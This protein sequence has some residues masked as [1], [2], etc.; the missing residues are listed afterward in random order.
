MHDWN[1]RSP[2][3][4][5][6]SFSESPCSVLKTTQSCSTQVAQAHTLT[7]QTM[8]TVWAV[9][10]MTQWNHLWNVTDF[11][12][13][14]S[15]LHHTVSDFRSRAAAAADCEDI[16]WKNCRMWTTTA[17]NCY[18]TFRN[19]NH[20]LDIYTHFQSFINDE[21]CSCSLLLL[22]WE[23][24]VMLSSRVAH[25]VFKMIMCCSITASDLVG[26]TIA[27]ADIERDYDEQ[28]VENLSRRKHHWIW[29]KNNHLMT[30]KQN[31]FF[32][33]EIEKQFSHRQLNSLQ[34]W[35]YTKLQN[36][37]IS[38]LFINKQRQEWN[39]KHSHSIL[40]YNVMWVWKIVLIRCAAMSTDALLFL[41][42]Y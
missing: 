14:H 11:P 35:W 17:K 29:E 38:N 8:T 34:Q 40:I 18:P 15:A 27:A 3:L 37:H 13:H 26:E 42:I 41:Q 22:I 19:T 21:M 2:I 12:H 16:A 32:W 7:I 33:T 39:C 1:V 23:E 6:V 24:A 31:S 30:L 5:T 36:T 9:K 10:R 25:I 28:K 20:E 4:R